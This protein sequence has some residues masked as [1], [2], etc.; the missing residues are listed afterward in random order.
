MVDDWLL[1]SGCPSRRRRS[2][3]SFVWTGS[4]GG[5]EAWPEPAFR[6]R[7]GR[8]RPRKD[9]TRRVSPRCYSAWSATISGRFRPS[10]DRA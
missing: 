8:G 6:P 4:G 9:A 5:P 3:A 2:S 7:P 1:T 10:R